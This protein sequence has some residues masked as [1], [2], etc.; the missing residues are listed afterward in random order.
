MNGVVEVFPAGV[1]AHRT[2]ICMAA[3]TSN[4][5]ASSVL[6]IVLLPFITCCHSSLS[7]FS[8]PESLCR[9]LFSSLSSPFSPATLFLP[10]PS[11]HSALSL[12][13][14]NWVGGAVG[15]PRLCVQRASGQVNG[16]LVSSLEHSVPLFFSVRSLTPPVN[17][18]PSVSFP[19]L[20]RLKLFFFSPVVSI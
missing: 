8:P 17:L 15:R 7:F 16:A 9:L 3:A 10:S 11:W 13:V 1:I 4:V 20:S 14:D 2:V 19:F 5:W 6:F 12:I 18:S